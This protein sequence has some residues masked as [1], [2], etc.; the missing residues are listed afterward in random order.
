MKP[1]QSMLRVGDML[2]HGGGDDNL[3]RLIRCVSAG[4]EFKGDLSCAVHT[5]IV[6][7]WRGHMLQLEMKGFRK[8]GGGI[9]LN[10][11]G[12]D[13]LCV[14]RHPAYNE[15]VPREGLLERCIRVFEDKPKY[16]YDGVKAFRLPW[17]KQD[18]ELFYCSELFVMLTKVDVEYPLRFFDEVSPRDLQVI[19]SGWE[20]V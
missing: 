17:R 11:I 6:V 10:V 20:T 13:V 1:D 7:E 15:A 12:D 3:S 18:H 5:S 9:E 14:R 4:R 19:R 8:G 16:D 2:C